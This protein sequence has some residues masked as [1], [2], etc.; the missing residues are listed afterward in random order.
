LRFAPAWMA[1][2]IFLLVAG[3]TW[4]LIAQFGRA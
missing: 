4:L 1:L 2:V 3:G